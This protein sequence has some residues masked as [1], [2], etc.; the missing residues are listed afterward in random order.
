MRVDVPG[1]ATEWGEAW[2]LLHKIPRL[3][4]TFLLGKA[5]V[6]SHIK[7]LF[8]PSSCIR[9]RQP[10][11]YVILKS[12][13]K[14][15]NL[16]GYSSASSTAAYPYPLLIQKQNVYCHHLYFLIS[17]HSCSF[18]T[19][20]LFGFSPPPSSSFHIA[21]LLIKPQPLKFLLYFSFL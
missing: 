16:N 19:Q 6:A 1:N 18:I 2:T 10:V 4:Q 8:N 20:H 7:R 11:I 14:V 5:R 21:H 13:V 9:F 15:F 12:S 3:E 17:F